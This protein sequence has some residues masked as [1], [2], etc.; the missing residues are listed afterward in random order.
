[1]A[2]RLVPFA[3]GFDRP[4]FVA[5]AGDG[6]GRLYVVEQG[7]RIWRLAA[8]GTR[9][10]KPFLDLRSKVSRSGNERGLLGLAFHPRYAENG[11]LFVHYTARNGDITVSEFKIGSEGRPGD[12]RVL[13]RIPHPRSNHNGGMLAFGPDG[14]LYIA[15][16]DGGGAGDPDR[17]GQDLGSLLGKILRIDVDGGDETGA[18]G[19]PYAVPPDNPFVGSS[20][21]RPEIWAFGLRNPWRF[22]FDPA[23]GALYIGDVGQDRAEEID[24]EP[25]G[26]GGRNYG[27]SVM[28][29]SGCY[30]PSDGCDR[31]GLTLPA[32]EYGHDEGCSVTGG[33]VY[34]GAKIPELR[35]AYVY[36]D[37][38]SGMVWGV[39]AA[40]ALT[41]RAKA[42]LLLE[43][44]REIA[45]FGVDEAGEL[46]LV[47]LGGTIYRLEIT[48]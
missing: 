7:G 23:T 41:G 47:D 31:E 29:G 45:S 12:E 1:V 33:Y 26:E 46:Y 5:G 32:V 30:R 25:A 10:V 20:G 4:V 3:S 16:G 36:G 11:R 28:E 21:A 38:C 24:V 13:L 37:Y 39:D 6:S 18:G 15:T 19:Q 35:G 34:R 48:G 42:T 14:M 8:D 2:V 40:D 17:A 44:G 22:A 27:W 9:E 43:S